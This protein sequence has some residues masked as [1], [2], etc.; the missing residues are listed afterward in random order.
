[1]P[2]MPG[3]TRAPEGDRSRRLVRKLALTAAIAAAWGLAQWLAP[4]STFASAT[5]IL[6]VIWLVLL[7]VSAARWLWRKLT[8]RVSVRLLLSY[9]LIGLVPFPLLGVLGYL[10]G[11]MLAGQYTAVRAGELIERTSAG[12]AERA[13]V[14]A[15]RIAERR[16]PLAGVLAD[17]IGEA[18]ENL[19]VEWLLGDGRGEWRTPG[20]ERVKIPGWVGPEGWRGAVLIDGTPWL[21]GVARRGDAVAV[22][23][24]RLDAVNAAHLEA[25]EWFALRFTG[26]RDTKPES[27]AAKAGPEDGRTKVRIGVSTPGEGGVNISSDEADES[28]IEKGWL[29]AGVSTGGNLLRRQKVVW[30]HVQPVARDWESGG[31]L[32]GQYVMALVR[33][34]LGA[35]WDDLMGGQEKIS[36]TLGAA[37]AIT[38]S[39]FGTVYLIAV[40]FAVVMIVSVARATSRLT[41]GAREVAGG[42][43][44]WRIPVKRRDQLGDL[45]V[46]FNA[47]TDAVRGMLAEVA[48]KERLARELELARE[49]QESL[50][51]PRDFRHAGLSV[52]AVFRPAAEVG[53]DY[54][55]L[56]PVAER[57]LVIA[58]GDVA[59]HGLSTG[60]LMAMVKSAVAALIQEGHRGVELLERLN[61]LLLGQELR[62]RMVTLA[63]IDVD[64][65]AGTVQVSNGGHP[66]VYV[67]A[68]DGAVEEVLAA[69]LPLGH[70]WPRPPATISAAFPAGSRLVIYSDGLVEALDPTGEQLGYD[71]LRRWLERHWTMPAAELLAALLAELDRHTGGAPLA[72]DLTV[73]VVESG[74][75]HPPA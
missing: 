72:D 1:M 68:P 17:D 58:A 4:E 18:P 42:N 54:F 31:N 53:G 45:A 47:M 24:A 46:S 50:L 23:L 37:L 32:Q 35:A 9:L 52:H 39:V 22:V 20:V 73:L 34:T 44:G 67:I 57:R 15:G 69:A 56:F 27:D 65:A 30:F 33:T 28:Q 75:G 41:R 3:L 11:Y 6:L 5:G 13:G 21:A 59:G 26:A 10:A 43:L 36:S 60:L 2:T 14:A 64:Q 63:L 66:P 29:N 62:H 16:S 70:R 51:P 61:T 7:G 48:E 19:N 38:A 71:A 25:G 49:I 12:L 55:D 8:Y 40:S 74:P